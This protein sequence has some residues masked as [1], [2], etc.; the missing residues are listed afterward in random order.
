MIIE[1]SRGTLVDACR[2]S[3]RQSE[4]V[5]TGIHDKAP[6]CNSRVNLRLTDTLSR[7]RYL[8]HPLGWSCL[9]SAAGVV[10]LRNEPG[11][12]KVNASSDKVDSPDTGYFEVVVQQV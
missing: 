3:A 9:L 1:V 11:R 7:A 2:R 4:S 5:Y 6:D 10:H 12:V 8:V